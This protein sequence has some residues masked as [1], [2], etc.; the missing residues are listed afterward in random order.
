MA[1]NPRRLLFRNT[2]LLVIA[3]VM[4][5]GTIFAFWPQPRLVE[6]QA[7]T[8][9]PMVISFDE[10]GQTQVR[11]IF[12]VTAPISGRLT[13]V[14]V[15][16][17]DEVI[18]SETVLARILPN[19]PPTMD[20]RTREQAEASVRAARAMVAVAETS[21]AVQSEG[22]ISA[23]G[24][25]ERK[26]MLLKSNAISLAAFDAA[27]GKLTAAGLAVETAKASLV[28][29]RAELD[30]AL[31][32]TRAF[33]ALE[34]REESLS[35]SQVILAPSDGVI[36]RLFQ[37]SEAPI[38]IGTPILEIGD[39]EHGLEIVAH[40]LTTE[41][42]QI[43]PGMAVKIDNWGGD[44][45]LNGIVDRVAPWAEQKISVL[46]VEE[47][48]VPVVI[49]LTS[50]VTRGFKLGH[51]YRADVQVLIWQ[52]DSVL[53]VSP[54]ALFREADDSWTVFVMDEDQKARLIAVEIGQRNPLQVEILAGLVAGQRV[55]LFPGDTL[56]DGDF[57]KERTVRDLR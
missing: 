4:V 32:Q 22:Q 19:P 45:V 12:T 16:P 13:R 15:L 2:I 23:Q 36:L 7:V 38:A 26:T 25:F 55:V 47:R 40:F 30:I 33:E 8:A 44:E 1:K 42:V 27:E 52:R 11:E 20:A 57:I 37:S 5:G 18:G 50:Q 6:T 53:T 35:D 17:G 31:A 9:T 51:G 24:D 43:Q 14:S 56:K 28:A 34:D 54:S 39:P 46:G 10:Q 49:K 3:A 29:R 48:R 41:A 21:L